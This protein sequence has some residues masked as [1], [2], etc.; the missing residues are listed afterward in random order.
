MP[1]KTAKS[2][3]ETNAAWRQGGLLLDNIF[4]G[5]HE[6]PPETLRIALPYRFAPRPPSGFTIVRKELLRHLTEASLLK[7]LSIVRGMAGSGKTTLLAQWRDVAGEM[8]RPVAW[9][10]VDAGDRDPAHFVTGLADALQGAGSND[11]AEGFR[12][13]LPHIGQQPAIV[14]AQQMAA[15]F[16][17]SEVRPVIVLDQY[18]DMDAAPTGEMI[19]TLLHHCLHA[20]LI[21]GSRR[22]PG[23][24]LGSIRARDQLFEIGPSDLNLSPTETRA[25]FDRE[26]PELY[27][28]RL[29]FETSGEAVAVGFARRVVDEL[30]RDMIGTENWQDQ[31]HEY[32]RTEVLDSL[33]PDLRAAMSRLVV[34]ERFDLSLASALLGHAATLMIERL[35]HIDGLLLR[36]RGT[37][38]FYFSEMLRRFLEK[39]LAWLEDDERLALHRRAATWFAQRGR[40]FEALR[41]AIAAEDRDLALG[42]LD[43]VGYGNLMTQ[44]GV[45]ATHQLLDEIGIASE[46]ASTGTLLSLALIEAHEGNIEQASAHLEKA[47]Q[48]MADDQK[49]DP[50]IDGQL[51]LAEAFVAGFRDETLIAATAPALERY[52]ATVPPGEHE[53]RAQALILLSWD[54]FC[55]GDT[56]GAESLTTAAADEY[57]ETEGAYGCI[58]MHVH[59]VIARFWRNDLDRAVEEITLADR[60]TRIFFPEDQRLRA[61]TG[62]LRAGLLFEIGRPDPLVDLTA[63]VG[64]VGA[65]ESWNEIQIWSHVQGARSAVAQGRHSEAR[66]IIAYGMEVARRLDAPRLAW[67]MRLASVD[68]ALRAGETARAVDEADE[69]SLKN[70]ALDLPEYLTWQERIGALI[71]A[72]RLAEAPGDLEGATACISRAREG[73]S[74]CDAPRF[75]VELELAEARLAHKRGDRDDA[76]A[77]ISAARAHCSGSLPVRLFLDAQAVLADYQ[78]E[79]AR[80]TIPTMLASSPVAEVV[81]TQGRD[82]L[83]PRE[84]QILLFMGEGHP[85]KVAAHQLG[86]SE[87]TVKFH[88]RNIYRKLHAQN[89]TQALARYRILAERR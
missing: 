2:S 19:S 48:R 10:T 44:Q 80:W 64:E 5:Q 78:A 36:H 34:V 37:Q 56:A 54:R 31:L 88:L 61:M 72:I 11:L 66:G 69:L 84:R 4:A 30:P 24:P 9:L 55:R 87:A 13:I 8:G 43:Q 26:V 3:G 85:N 35:H 16:N 83:T 6:G 40:L 45:A 59:R 79:F 33:P 71:I 32:Y 81:R 68:Q 75:S 29:H 28:R 67:A 27:T 53:G 18:E 14:A 74:L 58:F 77:H 50:G 76:V 47:R 25:M 15:V 62:A 82:P 41:H 57:A 86:L 63:L 52:L 42:L 1:H 89:R 38:E 65:L 60:M 21:I 73:L 22:R 46:V 20:R 70:A 7:Q 49:P 23:I 39:R 51:V 12:A 17:W